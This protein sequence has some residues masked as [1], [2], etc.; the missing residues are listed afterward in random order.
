MPL[1]NLVKQKGGDF[2]EQVLQ[3]E[4]TQIRLPKNV[5]QIGT[6]DKSAIIYIEDYVVTYL[7]QMARKEKLSFGVAALYGRTVF[8]KDIKYVFISGAVFEE[9]RPAL[10]SSPNDVIENGPTKAMLSSFHENKEKY[11]SELTSVG[12]AVIHSDSVRVPDA[13]K[14]KN[15]MGN[16]PGRGAV[17]IDL[18]T[19]GDGAEYYFY[20]EEGI[21]LQE[22]HY[23]YYEKNDMMQSFLVE[24]HECEQTGLSEEPLD[25]VAGTCR[26]VMDDKKEDRI[27]ER[28]ANWV[29]AS[30]LLSLIIISAIGI[31]VMNHYRET[32]ADGTSAMQTSELS[33]SSGQADTEETINL[34]TGTDVMAVVEEG[35]D[36]GQA[37]M[38]V[39]GIAND[40]VLFRSTAT[41]GIPIQLAQ[42]S[43]DYLGTAINAVNTVSG[44]VGSVM[45]GNITGAVTGAASGIGNTIRASMPDFSTSGSNGSI[46][47]FTKAPAISAR[48]HSVV[49]E[50]NADLGRPLCKAKR[51]DTIPG[52]IMCLHA[53]VSL[54][55]TAP[56]NQRVKEYMESGFFYE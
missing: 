44:V 4:C 12:I 55:A 41:F 5:R 2:V 10:Q 25:F 26:M 24:W 42:I 18:D 53:D 32:A 7:N 20:N 19:D 45:S 52:Y 39:R 23:I 13:F 33:V 46:V 38:M 17:M 40:Y 56:E 50:D 49:D 15:R 29:S 54:P 3:E 6:I 35:M 51:I 48:F 16:L 30:G 1:N 43:R 21:A 14:R 47:P 28:S 9:D 37:E 36:T 11:F 27:Q 34:Q 8:E 22:G 31:L